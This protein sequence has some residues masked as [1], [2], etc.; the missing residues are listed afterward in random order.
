MVFNCTLCEQETVYLSNHC[1]SCREIKNI[2][3]V[4]GYIEVLKILKRV[5]LRTA[6]QQ[7]HKIKVELKSDKIK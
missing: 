2:I 5:C 7:D 3:N 1:E 6:T 4:Y